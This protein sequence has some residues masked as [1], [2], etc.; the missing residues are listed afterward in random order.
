VGSPPNRQK[1][2]LIDAP[3]KSN[4]LSRIKYIKKQSKNNMIDVVI[5]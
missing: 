1:E 4:G 2:E 3:I 5:L